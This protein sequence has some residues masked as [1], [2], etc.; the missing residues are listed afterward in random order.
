M[1]WLEIKLSCSLNRFSSEFYCI[2]L[3]SKPF[4]SKRFKYC[5]EILRYSLKIDNVMLLPKGIVK[6]HCQWA[7]LV[8]G[9]QEA[10][11]MNLWWWI[12]ANLT[13]SWHPGAFLIVPYSQIPI[14]FWHSTRYLVMHGTHFQDHRPGGVVV[15]MWLSSCWLDMLYRIAVEIKLTLKNCLVKLHKS[16]YLNVSWFGIFNIHFICFVWEKERDLLVHSLNV[17]MSSAVTAEAKNLELNLVRGIW[18]DASLDAH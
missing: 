6:K 7:R 13:T 16:T 12:R 1:L 17:H 5:T 3:C 8:E 4:K 2:S 10:T 18:L 11:M 14:L 15:I 9:F